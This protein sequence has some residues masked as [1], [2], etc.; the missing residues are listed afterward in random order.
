MKALLLAAGIGSRLRPITNTIPKCMVPIQGRPLLDIWLEV[1]VTSGVTEILINTHYKAE[2]INEYISRSSW[3]DYVTLFHE[4]NLLGTGGTIL[5]NKKF[6]REE[7]F[8]VAHADNLSRFPFEEF[9]KSH[10]VSSKIPIVT[11]MLFKTD[12]PEKCGIVRLKDNFVCEFYE[13][14]NGNF[15][16]LANAAIYIFSPNIFKY[17]ECID[18]EQIDI[19]IDLLP[20]LLGDI[21][22]FL[23]NDYHID[24]GSPANYLKANNEFFPSSASRQ[25]KKL[26]KAM[27]QNLILDET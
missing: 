18:S 25:N 1:L 17:L 4:T 12:Q 23:N 3:K 5:A 19:S 6:F 26:W 11:M 14:M 9:K 10:F 8:F 2:F 22:S 15:G 13:K 27:S 16:N 20:L 7:S 21:N 24:I